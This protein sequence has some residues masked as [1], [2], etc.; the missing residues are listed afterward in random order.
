M[1]ARWKIFASAICFLGFAMVVFGAFGP[2]QGADTLSGD[3][4]GK[5]GFALMF[6]AIAIALVLR[7]K[8]VL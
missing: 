7:R 4:L 2:G 6:I 8:R 5:I 3:R 1:S